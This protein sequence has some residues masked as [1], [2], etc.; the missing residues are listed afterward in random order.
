MWSEAASFMS[1]PLAAGSD[2]LDT[3]IGSSA[4]CLLPLRG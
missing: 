1:L 3:S 2:S 4:I